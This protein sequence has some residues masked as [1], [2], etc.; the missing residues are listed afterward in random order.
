[1]DTVFFDMDGTLIDTEK[2][3]NVCWCEAIAKFGY[4]ITKEEALD[5]RSLGRPH[6]YRFFEEK[7]GKGFPYDEMRAYR[8]KIMEEMLKRDGIT[9]KPGAKEI[10]LWLKSRQIRCMIATATDLERTNRY[11]EMAGLSSYFDEII[12]AVMVKNGKPSP[13]IYQLACEKAGRIPS[14]CI[15]IEDSPNGVRAAA[16]AGCRVFMIPD[17]D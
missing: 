8:K 6:V 9:V 12:S 4:T 5:L 7:Y 3:Y 17:L 2:Y 14:D 13:D 11:L 1:M 16:A 10:L 15:A